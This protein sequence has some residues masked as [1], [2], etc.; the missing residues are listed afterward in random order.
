MNEA[1]LNKRTINHKGMRLISYTLEFFIPSPF[2][3]NKFTNL[4]SVF[5]QD[6]SKVFQRLSKMKLRLSKGE[7]M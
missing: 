2:V 7:F 3:S 4:S 1:V 5:A 6:S